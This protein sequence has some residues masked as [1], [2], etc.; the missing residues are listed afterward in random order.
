MT[1]IKSYDCQVLIYLA[2]ILYHFHIFIHSLINKDLLIYYIPERIV[3]PENTKVK[4]I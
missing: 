4:K 1:I 2:N 3:Q